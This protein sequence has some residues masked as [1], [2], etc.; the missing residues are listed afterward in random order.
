MNDQ[1]KSVNKIILVFPEGPLAFNGVNY[2]Y[3]KGERLYLDRLAKTFSK[4]VIVSQ[5]L[6]FG[7]P[8]YESVLHST[9]ESSNLEVF[10]LPRCGASIGVFGKFK[11]FVKIF[12]F[13]TPVVLRGDI[14]YLFLP[15]YPSAMGWIW[16]RLLRKKHI[17]Y[18]A[19]DWEQASAGM[20][21]WP[22]LRGS[23]FYRLYCKLNRWMEEI[24]VS[25]ALFAVAAGGQLVDKYRTYGIIVQP[26]SPR[27][28]ISEDDIFHRLDTCGGTVVRL[29]NVGSLNYDKAQHFLIE[30]FA[31][32]VPFDSRLRLTVVGSGERLSELVELTER[33]G[34]VDRVEFLGY[35]EDTAQLYEIYRNSD[36]FVL[37]SVSEGFPRVLYEAMTFGLPIVTTCCGGIGDL[38]VDSVNGRVVSVS[39]SSAIADAISNIILDVQQRREIIA[40]GTATMRQIFKNSDHQQIARMYSEV[41]KTTLR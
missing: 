21:K 32:L 6:R 18:G 15:S 11:H 8:Y 14:F 37:S 12:F 38:I 29:I 7:D 33:L 1:I 4:V 23:L 27:I 16:A 40:N 13:M 35:I 17:V 5:V 41:I 30:A 24:I 26:T 39:S 25:S 10:E 28:V 3:S 20:F 36:I 19:D 22:H 34:I 31:T 2:C 9:F